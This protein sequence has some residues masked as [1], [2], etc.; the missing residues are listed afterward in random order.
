M[1]G[2]LHNHPSRRDTLR[3]LPILL[4][5]VQILGCSSGNPPK[6]EAA[7]ADLAALIERLR[8]EV[9]APGAILGVA[10]ADGNVQVVASGVADRESGK[11]L[12]PDNPYYLGSI[13]KTYTAVVVLRLVEQG[14]LSLDDTLHRFLPD[15]PK[16]NAVTVRHLLTHTSGLRDFYAY[17]YYRPDYD[18]M[19]EL[20]TKRWSEAE[21]LELSGRFGY[22]FEPGTDWDYSSTNYYLLGVIA[23]RTSGLSLVEAYRQLIYSP[24]DIRRTWLPKQEDEL[25]PLPTGYL[26]LVKGWK[27]SERFGEL[28]ATTV[29][30]GS[31]VELAAGGLAA[32]AEDALRFLRGLVGGRLLQPASF[33]AMKEFRA[34]PALGN[35]NGEEGAAP[36]PE[37]YGMGL[38]RMERAGRRLIGHGGL[39]NG[40]SAG[41]WHLP[42]CDLTLTLYFNR[43]L[44]E[45]RPALDQIVTALTQ[46]PDGSTRCRPKP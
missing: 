32:S 31:S 35:F 15:F 10:S 38:A 34:T 23:Q 19:V 39:Y 30:D 27:H 17:F 45:M 28:G 9:G 2:R 46:N 7:P 12:T 25:A 13:T 42:D 22:S 11:P 14:R 1:L 44:L 43:G 24:L 18:E 6:N 26:G 37:G 41:L 3:I 5:L 36:E 29:L 21:L 40:H 4:A 20:V 16:G 8:L 33:A